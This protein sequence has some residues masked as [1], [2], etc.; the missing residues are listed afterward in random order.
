[1]SENAVLAAMRRMDIRKEEMS[2]HG[3]RAVARTIPDE[4]LGFRTDIIEHQL[5]HAVRDANGTAYNRTQHLPERKKMMQA[6]ADYIAAQTKRIL[7]CLGTRETRGLCK[8]AKSKSIL[9]GF[10][11]RENGLTQVEL[12]ETIMLTFARST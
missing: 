11:A 9:E 2:G 8:D 1:M 12:V 4:V 10:K 3:F 6:W 7:V 5:A